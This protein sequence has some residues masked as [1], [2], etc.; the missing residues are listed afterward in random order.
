M[1]RSHVTTIYSKMYTNKCSIEY[2]NISILKIQFD[3]FG[4]V[5]T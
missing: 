3:T 2:S 4:K 1:V 5:L